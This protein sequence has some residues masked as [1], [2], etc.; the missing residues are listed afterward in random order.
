[1]HS[2][3]TNVVGMRLEACDFLGCIVVVHADLEVIRTAYDPILAGNETTRTNRDIC[4]FECFDDCFCG[5]RPDVD[6]STV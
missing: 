6:M 5:K 2:D 1:M 3:G 4:E